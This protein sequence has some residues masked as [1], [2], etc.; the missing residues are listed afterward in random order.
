[1]RLEF[2]GG[3]MKIEKWIFG[4]AICA[5][6]SCGQQPQSSSSTVQ[7]RATLL[8]HKE[9]ETMTSGGGC[10]GIQ[11]TAVTY[12]CNNDST[13]N[14]FGFTQAG[15]FTVTVRGAST[16]TAAAGISVLVA[17]TKVAALSFT[18]TIRW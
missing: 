11:A 2:K 15:R 18:G 13:F 5:L 16:N 10:T 7:T 6:V 8:T 14:S 4:F 12:Y 1:M 9:A 3:F 17:G